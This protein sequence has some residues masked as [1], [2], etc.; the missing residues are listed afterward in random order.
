[1]RIVAATNADL[2]ERVRERRFRE[3]LYWRLNVLPIRVPPLRERPEDVGPIAA[4]LV[5]RIGETSGRPVALSRAARLALRDAEWP[6]NV[7]QLENVLARAWAT[8]L[9]AGSATIEPGHVFPDR[10]APSTA[11]PETYAEALRRFQARTLADALE[12][13]GWNVSEAARRLDLSRSH[14]CDL[15]KAHG[16]SR[17]R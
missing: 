15:V 4:H 8:A 9:A 1:V 7:R 12:A 10:P 6:G 14:L 17:K 13:C 16:L 2:A 5:R 11:S 3:D